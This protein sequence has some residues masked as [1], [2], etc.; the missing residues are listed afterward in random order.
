MRIQYKSFQ[1]VLDTL[2]EMKKEGWR[3]MFLGETPEA[4]SESRRIRMVAPG[5]NLARF[6]LLGAVMYHL[7]CGGC[8]PVIKWNK[9]SIGICSKQLDLLPLTV[10]VIEIT[11]EIREGRKIKPRYR[12]K[13]V[14][15]TGKPKWRREML[16]VLGFCADTA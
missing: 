8:D 11:S 16:K 15:R 1:W 7:G 2:A 4:P 13:G 12:F 5:E 3:A 10:F 14:M 6:S 9:R